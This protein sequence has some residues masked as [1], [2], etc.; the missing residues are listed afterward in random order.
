MQLIQR[1]NIIIWQ[2]QLVMNLYKFFFSPV[3]TVKEF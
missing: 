1:K 2:L 3:G